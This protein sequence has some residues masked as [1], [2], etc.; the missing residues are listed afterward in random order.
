MDSA[1][2]ILEMD[3]PPLYGNY[4]TLEPFIF[5]QHAETL[6]TL[7]G[8]DVELFQ[9]NLYGPFADFASFKEW[10]SPPQ[11][12]QK[13]FIVVS[14]GEICG[15]V[16]IHSV[17]AI[18]AIAEIGVTLA[19]HVHKT[20]VLTESM[21]LLLQELFEKYNF[22]RV[23]WHCI[24]KNIASMNAAKRLGFTEEAICRNYYVYKNE[25]LDGLYFSIIYTE[26]LYIKNNLLM[27]LD[28]SNF[29]ENGQQKYKLNPY[30]RA[31]SSYPSLS[32]KKLEAW[33]EVERPAFEALSSENFYIEKLD[34]NK[35]LDAILTL[36][37]SDNEMFRF[38]NY[39]NFR[40]NE[41]LTE[42]FP[43]F[44]EIWTHYCVFYKLDNQLKSMVS[45][46][47]IS[48]DSGIIE[49]FLLMVP[50]GQYQFF[51]EVFTVLKNHLFNE[52]GYRRLQMQVVVEDDSSIRLIESLGFTCDG[53]LRK[54]AVLNGYSHDVVLFSVTV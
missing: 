52:L 15:L 17:D 48:G 43:R 11:V 38:K 18:N 35:H 5:E 13:Q 41:D 24:C 26:W 37:E 19:R 54:Y 10:L 23:Q 32:Y 3:L 53:V 42:W 40:K 22:R 34:L 30:F 39:S 25:C 6:F 4:C 21:Y 8:S 31:I 7:F 14:Q 20:P 16:S 28:P 33:K 36:A 47:Y 2:N 12:V 46:I 45:L 44:H 9:N 50:G 29:D 49:L 27:W 51:A 1:V